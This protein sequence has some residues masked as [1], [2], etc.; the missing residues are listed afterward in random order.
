MVQLRN[1][2]KR[3]GNHPA[4]CGRH[5]SQE[6]NRTGAGRSYVNAA[7]L[8]NAATKFPSREGWREAPGWC[9]PQGV[10]RPPAPAHSE[11]SRARQLA[12]EA[13]P[14]LGTPRVSQVLGAIC[15]RGE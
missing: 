5:P 4:V 15:P 13:L 11:A 1:C 9:P 2:T 14:I 7:I 6:G 3:G 8:T 10:P 12:R